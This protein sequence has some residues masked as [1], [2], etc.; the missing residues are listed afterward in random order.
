VAC[1][2]V[3]LKCFT[4][5]RLIGK[6]AELRVV[7]SPTAEQPRN[8]ACMAVKGVPDFSLSRG[9]RRTDYI[10]EFDAFT[11]GKR[12]PRGEVSTGLQQWKLR[13]D[14][15]LRDGLVHTLTTRRP[16]VLLNMTLPDT[17]SKGPHQSRQ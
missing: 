10:V 13:F 5:L 6:S 3:V 14:G 9:L 12:E 8:T 2:A 4:N 7:L 1:A 11:A 15:L 16:G 17:A